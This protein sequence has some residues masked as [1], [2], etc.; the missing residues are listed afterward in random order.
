MGVLELWSFRQSRE[1]ANVL[2]VLIR[3]LCDLQATTTS[4]SGTV[5]NEAGSKP[6]STGPGSLTP[7]QINLTLYLS[8]LAMAR[9]VVYHAPGIAQ[10]YYLD[11]ILGR[12]QID[13]VAFQSIC[14]V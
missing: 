6:P 12:W 9:L 11:A 3:T 7:T 14:E 4:G 1:T 2:L 13:F 5:P 8:R 10:E